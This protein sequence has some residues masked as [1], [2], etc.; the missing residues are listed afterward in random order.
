MKIVLSALVVLLGLFAGF[1]YFITQDFYTRPLSTSGKQ[2]VFTVEAG[3]SFNGV[4]KKLEEKNLIRSANLLILVARL[5]NIR[6]KLKAGDYY[7]NAALSPKDIMQVL[8]SGKSILRT[9][10]VSE[11]LNMY[12][13]AHLFE[14]LGYGKKSEF[15]DVCFNKEFL[16]KILGDD[17]YSCE[18]YLFPETYNIEKKT[19]AEKLV[20]L[21][22]KLFLKNYEEVNRKN[23]LDGWS[24]HQIITLASIIEKETGQGSERP[25]ISAVFHNRLKKKMKLQTDPTVLYGILDQTRAYRDNITRKDLETPSRYNTY[26]NFGLPYGPISNPGKAAITAVFEPADSDFLFFVSKNNGTHIFSKTYE[27]HNQNVKAFQLNAKAREGKSWRNAG[28]T[29]NGGGTAASA[30]AGNSRAGKN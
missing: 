17:V 3:D 23:N 5:N 1:F 24:R 25:L 20:E 29:E 21:M 19:S 30:G 13:V 22:L 6:S 12:E 11:G 4:A 8:I 14:K 9:F 7:L 16:H 18:G 28:T 27:E 10:T 2:T 26:T 15:L